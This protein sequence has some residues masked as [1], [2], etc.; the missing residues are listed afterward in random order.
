MKKIILPTLLASLL[1]ACSNTPESEL[2]KDNCNFYGTTEEAPGWVCEPKAYA[3]D[4]TVTETASA[5]KSKLGWDFQE[6]VAASNAR[7]KLA[8]EIS[9]KVN[10]Y[11]KQYL[12][13]AGIAT[14]AVVEKV[15]QQTQDSF[16]QADL[17][18]TKVIKRAADSEGTLWVLVEISKADLAKAAS[19]YLNQWKKQLKADKQL[20][21]ANIAFDELGQKVKD[22]ITLELAPL[23]D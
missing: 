16:T 18:G 15:I 2:S 9:F 8:N 12:R 21:N 19:N 1:M 4:E 17:I 22:N 20:K 14:D 6:T 7:L 13:E 23:V 10:S 3:S 5:N 11:T